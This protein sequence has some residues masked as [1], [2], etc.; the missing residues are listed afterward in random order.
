M[1]WPPALVER[2]SDRCSALRREA[3]FIVAQ[4]VGGRIVACGEPIDRSPRMTV[5]RNAG[6]VLAEHTTLEL[7]CVDRMYLNV[8]VPVL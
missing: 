1:C 5:A 2:D 8:Y 6:E 7:E 3:A 4:S